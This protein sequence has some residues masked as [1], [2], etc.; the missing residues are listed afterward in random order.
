MRTNS[1]IKNVDIK[2]SVHDAFSEHPSSGTLKKQ[3]GQPNNLS[4][5]RNKTKRP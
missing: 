3:I 2:F 5:G 4:F 1:I